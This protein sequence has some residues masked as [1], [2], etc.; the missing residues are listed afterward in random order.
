MIQ[1]WIARHRRGV[2]IIVIVLFVALLGWGIYS[3]YLSTRPAVEISVSQ[4]QETKPQKTQVDF[5]GY[6]RKVSPSLKSD[7]SAAIT[8]IVSKADSSMKNYAATVRE[9]SYTERTVN[10]IPSVQMLVDVPVLPS[11]YLVVFD[12][13]EGYEYSILNTHCAPANQQM[14]GAKECIDVE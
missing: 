9:G 1:D 11:T 13:G 4:T 2:A 7:I 3:W 12:G 14:E 6:D 5:G 10:G 8:S